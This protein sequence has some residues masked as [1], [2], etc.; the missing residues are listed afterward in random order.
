MRIELTIKTT[1]LPE[2]GI[3]EGIREL[4]QNARDAETEFGASMTIRHR[5]PHTLC[6]ENEGTVLPHEA[7][8]LGFTSKSGRSDMIGKFGEGLK[9]GVLALVR[10]GFKIKIRSGSEVWVPRIVRSEKFDAEVLAFDV[11]KGRK[12]ERRVQIEVEGIDA[13]GWRI[14]KDKFLF[15]SK[16]SD[17][18]CVS[19]GGSSILTD[20]KL[21]GMVFVRGIHVYK[22][23]ELRYG[24]DLTDVEIDRDR[25]MID[26]SS[27]RWRLAYLWQNV[28]NERPELAAEYTQ[29]LDD[30]AEDLAGLDS[31][32]AKRLSED[33]RQKITSRFLERHGD[34]AL[35]VVNLAQSS[36]IEHLGMKGVVVPGAL[37]AVLEAQLGTVEEN[38]HKLTFLPK[39]TY[40]WGELSPEERFNL[41]RAI[42][43]V[44][45]EDAVALS[46]VDVVDFRTDSVEGLF[47]E[48]K[49][50][51]AK[52]RLCSASKTLEVLVHE[53][54]HKHG[55][56]G[57]KAHVAS[58]ERIW[59]GI[60]GK[61]L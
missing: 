31:Y 13:E 37:R 22:S 25:K 59:S 56:D 40:S 7:L 20:P 47:C 29:L 8:L 58:I 34:N 16:L 41:K 55:G 15:L 27:L 46:E 52:N 61:L 51:V 28:V 45:A 33:L 21:Q 57:E 60:V 24:Y 11:H 38:K 44:N 50:S 36:E 42:E 5:A 49:I 30:Q 6:I 3:W 32:S 12:D 14:I 9:L 54:A 43:L 1:Y 26:Q 17:R 39:R 53:V 10:K 2:W 4:I 23:P 18:H 19:Y 35:P 48:G